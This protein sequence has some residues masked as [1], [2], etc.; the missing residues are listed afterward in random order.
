MKYRTPLVAAS[1]VVVALAVPLGATGDARGQTATALAPVSS[2]D[3]IADKSKRAVALFQ[4]AG[5]VIMHPR[6]VN[7]HTP[8]D[9]PRQGDAMRLHEPPVVRG[10]GGKGAPGMMCS[11][12]HGATNYESVPGDPNW[13][14]APLDMAWIGR[15]LGQICEQIKDPK[16]NGGKSLEQIVEHMT[17][18]HLVGWGWNPGGGRTAAPGN[19]KEFGALIK[20]WVGSGAHC[21]RP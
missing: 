6:C 5:K 4:E 12:C 3:G 18:D 17:D 14:L 8:D 11:T 21:P 9:H 15:S 13:H 16:R 19:Q 1:C 20:A 2:F 10:A 7:C